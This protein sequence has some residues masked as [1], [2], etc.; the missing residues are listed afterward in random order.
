MNIRPVLELIN[1]RK[2]EAIIRSR[3]VICLVVG[4]AI[5][6]RLLAYSPFDL[7]HSDELMQYLEQGNRL[8]TGTGILPWESRF[9][10]RN[11]LIPQILAGPLWL[12]HTLAPGTIA[13]VH[14]A[15]CTFMALTLLLLPAA[16]RLGALTSPRHGFV[17]LFVAATW[18]ESI[19]FSNLLL[20]ESLASAVLLLASA[21]LLDRAAK[22][23]KIFAAALLLGC[24]VLL[25]FQYAPFAAVVLVWTLVRDSWRWPY[26]LGGGIVAAVFGTISDLCA[27]MTPY[28]WVFV[29]FQKNIGEGIAAR[30]STDPAWQYL[31]E[32]YLH[33]GPGALLLV[34]ITA[35]AS[36]FR[37]RPLLAAAILN[38]A[39]HS[40]V[41]HKEYR[42][43]WL[44]TLVL[45]LL[46]AIGSLRI[47]DHLLARRGS[48]EKIGGLSV[49]IVV[50]GWALTSAA[51][52]HVTGG[53]KAFRGGGVLS[54]LAIAAA[55]RP[56][57]CG[58]VVAD[59]YYGYAAPSLL[60]RNIPLFIAPAGV[61]HMR[62]AL[63]PELGSAANALIS[64][65]KPV[66][67]DAFRQVACLSLPT[68]TPCLYVRPGSCSHNDTYDY[69]T[70]L[71]GAGM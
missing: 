62:R 5:A 27:G 54:E 25:R 10:L 13:H 19:F 38:V 39:V 31:Y 36:G 15:R 68:Q 18:W 42:F 8:V 57:V 58:L 61:Y 21:V 69:Q 9:G 16:W 40:L 64:D 41:L 34:G 28:S 11:S 29:N 49:L 37:Y 33:L 59:V 66:G 26:L 51:S 60:P 35:A 65:R 7:S 24:G 30:F 47:A 55:E 32:Y 44:S 50:T 1:S 52:F 70:M 6:L 2:M 17:A 20:S 22:G 45:L 12:G 14:L 53:Y 63:P 67:A 23:W 4:I 71:I 48:V 43:V 3:F 46:A 56:D